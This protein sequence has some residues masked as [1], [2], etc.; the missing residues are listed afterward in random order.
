MTPMDRKILLLKRGVTLQHVQRALRAG[1]K[2]LRST[3][4]ISRV[5]TGKQTADCHA[6]QEAVAVL[7]GVSRR[8]MFGGGRT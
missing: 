6:V 3:S 2:P 5:I 4:T 1:G 7:C 8:Q